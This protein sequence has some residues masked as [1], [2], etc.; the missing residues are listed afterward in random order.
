VRRSRSGDPPS[1]VRRQ[2]EC[3]EEGGITATLP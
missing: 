1:R 3:R 2:P